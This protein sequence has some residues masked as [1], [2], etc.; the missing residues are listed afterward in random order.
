M[1]ASRSVRGQRG[2]HISGA[3][4]LYSDQDI[5]RVVKEYIERA[6]DHP[7]GKADEI[8]IRIE[9][10]KLR[11]KVISALPLSTLSCHSPA[12]GRRMITTLLQS[13]GI[14]Q[15]AIDIAFASVKKGDMRGAAVL[16]AETGR[17][18]EPDKKR[19]VRVSR[20]GIS[21]PALRSISSGLSRLGIN[22]DTVKEALTLASKVASYRDI[23][24]ELCVSDDPDYTTGYVASKR[25][26][27]VRIPE[28]K[29]KGSKSGGRAFF[30]HEGSDIEALMDY[31]ERMPVLIGKAA[32]CRGVVSKDEILSNPYQ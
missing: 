28:I 23:I 15:K 13:L 32:S 11:P 4:G 22:T 24:A 10:I 29:R 12:E 21:K 6:T 20:L 5:Q 8:V 18:L 3:E 9:E 7:K 19:G 31:F 2:I 1:R 30:V 16:T 25:F 17:R 27:Y 14:S 26:G